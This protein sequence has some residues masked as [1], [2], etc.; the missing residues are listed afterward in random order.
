M[1]VYPSDYRINKRPEAVIVNEE[2][3]Q[4]VHQRTAFLSGFTSSLGP[5]RR[6]LLFDK[7]RR[8]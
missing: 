8:R 5:I 4:N 3:V 7:D 6:G 1:D 2:N